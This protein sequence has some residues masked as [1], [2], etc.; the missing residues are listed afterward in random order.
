MRE[1]V[2]EEEEEK[3]EEVLEEF[4]PRLIFRLCAPGLVAA[5]SR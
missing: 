1:E 3:E 4:H 2:L 5:G